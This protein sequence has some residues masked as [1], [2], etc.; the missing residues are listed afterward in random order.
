MGRWF[1]LHANKAFLKI[2]AAEEKKDL[3]LE[4]YSPEGVNG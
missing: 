4:T 2:E 3:A 1:S